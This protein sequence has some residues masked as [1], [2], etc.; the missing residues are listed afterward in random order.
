MLDIQQVKSYCDGVIEQGEESGILRSL[1][2]GID[3]LGL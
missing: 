3:A 2:E 1:F